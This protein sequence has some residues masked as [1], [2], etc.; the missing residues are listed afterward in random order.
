M[1][2][3]HKIIPRSR[4]FFFIV[5]ILA[6]ACLI[7]CGGGDSSQRSSAVSPPSG[8]LQAPA[9]TVTSTVPAN[10]SSGLPFNSGIAVT[11]SLDIDAA[12]LT[13]STFRVS[14]MTGT[15]AY[16]TTNK[17]AVFHP[18][19]PMAASTAYSVVLTTG[20]KSTAGVALASEYSFNFS[21]ANAPDLT[22]PTVTSVFPPDGAT[23]VP[24]DTK[25]TAT[26][27]E[28]MDATML[29]G[30]TATGS[31]GSFVYD[32]NTFTVTL[33]PT[34]KLTPSM[35]YAVTVKGTARD[36]AGNEMGIDKVWSFTTVIQ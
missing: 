17:T 27:S 22:P 30:T 32:S 21:T 16:D 25:I 14:N 15:I 13:P 12:T 26:F 3:Q 33:T 10:G 29:N 28:A 34:A 35:I 2:A 23:N 19:S 7:G 36:L 20:I 9:P 18:S 6:S 31:P 1:G 8:L 5:F 4:F 11:F 24:L